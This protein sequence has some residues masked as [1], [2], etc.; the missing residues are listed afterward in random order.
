MG[1]VSFIDVIEVEVGG[2]DVVYSYIRRRI[3]IDHWCG[4]QLAAVSI[5]SSR[6]IWTFQNSDVKKFEDNVAWQK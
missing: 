4:A 5:W 2:P 3:K 1:V 6:F